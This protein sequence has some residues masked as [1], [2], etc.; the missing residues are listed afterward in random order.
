[1]EQLI[2]SN[3][4]HDAGDEVS[5]ST[6]LA[7]FLEQNVADLVQVLAWWDA[8]TLTREDYV[9]ATY[10]AYTTVAPPAADHLMFN[11]DC[12]AFKC[13]NGLFQGELVVATVIP[14]GS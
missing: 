8:V 6:R 14:I 1:M 4:N 9:K 11:G 2:I 7:R 5:V 10:D 12:S 3:N 13:G